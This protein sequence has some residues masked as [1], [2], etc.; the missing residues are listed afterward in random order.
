MLSTRRQS[1]LLACVPPSW[2]TFSLSPIPV[3]VHLPQ[4]TSQ[5]CCKELSFPSALALRGRQFF[6]ATS[7]LRTS[8]SA[9]RQPNG[10]VSGCMERNPPLMLGAEAGWLVSNE[11]RPLCFAQEDCSVQTSWSLFLRIL[12]FLSFFNSQAAGAI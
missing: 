1:S 7:C 10:A 11:Q 6:L 2:G 5:R 4:R 9:I 3:S 8:F 12:P